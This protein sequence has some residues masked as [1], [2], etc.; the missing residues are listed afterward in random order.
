MNE[1]FLIG[2]LLGGLAMT[3][4]VFGGLG[5]AQ[6]L[7]KSRREEEI[8][9]RL[10]RALDKIREKECI[11]EQEV[12]HSAKVESDMAFTK[13]ICGTAIEQTLVY[14]EQTPAIFGDKK[15]AKIIQELHETLTYTGK[16]RTQPVALLEHIVSNGGS[17][18]QSAI[19]G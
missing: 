13:Q 5:L 4:L 3:I 11:L 16:E 19:N 9:A 18:E 6:W 8:Q 2:C 7:D 1:S 15:R 17:N 12:S 14:L 10:N